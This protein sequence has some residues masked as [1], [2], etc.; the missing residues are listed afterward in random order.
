MVVY[1]SNTYNI[2]ATFD[3][4]ITN[5]PVITKT[6]TGT[7]GNN[8]WFT[9]NVTVTWTVTNG[10][11]VS[12]CGTQNFTID[13]TGVESSCFAINSAGT[14]SNS[15]NLKIDKSAPT[16]FLNVVTGT[17]GNNDWYTSDVT[18]RTSC[19][20]TISEI[21]SYTPDQYQTT[22]TTGQIFNG[23]CTNKAGLVS[24][25]PP[26]TIKL[27]KNYPTDPTDV[28]STT[29]TVDTSSTDNTISMAWS[30]IGTIN[31]AS[32]STSGVS[33][34][35]YS[36]TSGATD[37]PDTTTDGGSSTVS[38]TS[39][40]LAS[41]SWYFHL[42]TVDNAGNWTGTVH[43]GPYIVTGSDVPSIF[44][45]T[46]NDTNYPFDYS[47]PGNSL[48]KTVTVSGTGTGSAPPGDASQYVQ[49]K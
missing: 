6:I 20:D 27:D 12:G 8:G 10:E 37:E 22:D 4:I 30:S 45:T 15:V 39:T 33:G 47:C 34:F 49:F 43:S 25:P 42:R 26:L 13:T 48:S 24:T 1:A 3:L 11:I 41:G 38:A 28:F 2:N 36:F 23:Q 31:G 21:D 9:S 16:A 32:D 44:I 19:S 29:H 5:P 14:S 17:L 35:S 40:P 7:E 46:I 18:I